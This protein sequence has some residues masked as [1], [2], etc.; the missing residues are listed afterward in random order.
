MTT[1]S[2][3]DITT[4]IQAYLPNGWFGDWANAP[5]IGGVI[6]GIAS[7]LATSYL[8]IQFAHAQTRL[9]TSSGGW[10]DLWATDFFGTSLPRQPSET[11]VSYISRIQAEIFQQK[12]T[13]PAMINMLTTLTGRAPIVFEPNRPLDTGCM[14][15]NTG[16]NSFCG[17]GRMGSLAPY[18]ALITAYRPKTF[19]G[20]P[21]AGYCNAIA[22][23]GMHALGSSSYT[24][25]LSAET[26]SASDAMI[27]AAINAC[28]PIGTNIGVCISS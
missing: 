8:L 6:S 4:R 24:G 11:D 10:I 28:R 20:T 15:M 17:A 1:G 5:I 23:S 7:V 2:Q 9:G 22:Y 18:M 26:S 14:G 25:S 3:S 12:S 27:Y 13:R 19:G 21:G 16:P